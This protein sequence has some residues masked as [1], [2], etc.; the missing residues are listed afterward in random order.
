MIGGPLQVCWRQNRSISNRT[1]TRESN[2]ECGGLR[3]DLMKFKDSP[4]SRSVWTFDL[5]WLDIPLKTK[6]TH[7][8]SLTK[9]R[10]GLEIQIYHDV[11]V[12]KI[13]IFWILLRL[14]VHF[15]PTEIFGAAVVEKT[16]SVRFSSV[17]QIMMIQG[18][19][20]VYSIIWSIIE[21]DRQLT[22]LLTT[23]P[24]ADK[25]IHCTWQWFCY[26]IFIT[27]CN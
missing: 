13:S 19:T 21:M 4:D 10:S 17:L 27:L 5:G 7:K 11:V 8:K 18:K 16:W 22:F 9:K 15:G 6:N 24:T 2:H 1:Q 25:R 23:C 14:L 20:W 12:V 3:R 26:S